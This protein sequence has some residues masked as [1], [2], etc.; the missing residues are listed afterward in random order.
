M[1]YGF[2][3]KTTKWLKSDELQAR[4]ERGTESEEHAI[5]FLVF[6]SSFPLDAR[7]QSW[8]RNLQMHK[9]M[10]IYTVLELYKKR[11]TTSS[12]ECITVF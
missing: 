7:G 4:D 6:I 12:V 1:G 9:A 2:D 10:G 5:S 8:C 11:V 3:S